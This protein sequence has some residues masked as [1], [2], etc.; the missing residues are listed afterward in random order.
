MSSADKGLA[1]AVIKQH[2]SHEVLE[3]R[4]ETQCL[5]HFKIFLSCLH[6]SIFNS[7]PIWEPVGFILP[8]TMKLAGGIS[9]GL[10]GQSSAELLTSSYMIGLGSVK[11]YETITTRWANDDLISSKQKHTL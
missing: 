2:G 3:L 6:R 7:K 5:V 9:S 1:W 8:C 4:I 11:V 10:L